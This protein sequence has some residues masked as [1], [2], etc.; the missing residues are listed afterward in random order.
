MEDKAE[1]YD[2]LKRQDARCA[3][4]QVELAAVRGMS[5][6]VLNMTEVLNGQAVGQDLKG[7][8]HKSPSHCVNVVLLILALLAKN[9]MIVREIGLCPQSSKLQSLLEQK[10]QEGCSVR[11]GVVSDGAMQC[12]F[13]GVCS[14]GRNVAVHPWVP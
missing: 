5:P 6:L 7:R 4:H 9:A 3:R 13:S 10:V 14:M 12:P 11:L 8:S 1:Q 2:A